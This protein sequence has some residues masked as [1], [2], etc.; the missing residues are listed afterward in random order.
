LAYRRVVKDGILKMTT[1]SQECLQDNIEL[2][3]H[4]VMVLARSLEDDAAACGTLQHVAEL[5]KPSAEQA[6]LLGS[7]ASSSVL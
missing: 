1:V 3:R 2:A 7:R 5:L 6:K 4:L